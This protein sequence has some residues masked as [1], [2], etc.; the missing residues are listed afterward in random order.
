[1]RADPIELNGGINLYLYVDGD[2]INLIDP[3]GL[4]RWREA[5]NSGLGLIR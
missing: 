3:M 2:P 5:L 4:I 1:M